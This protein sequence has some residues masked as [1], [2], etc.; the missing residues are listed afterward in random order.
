ML[1]IEAL[2]AIRGMRITGAIHIVVNLIDAIIVIT[3]MFCSRFSLVE[4]AK[5]PPEG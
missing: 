1:N 3:M 5:H 4:W 2:V